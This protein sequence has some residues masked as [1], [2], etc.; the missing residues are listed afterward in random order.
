MKVLAALLRENMKE[1]F[2]PSAVVS[3]LRLPPQ[4]HSVQP[5]QRRAERI[6]LDPSVMDLASDVAGARR[7]LVGEVSTA[8]CM[9]FFARVAKEPFPVPYNC[10]WIEDDLGSRGQPAAVFINTEKREFHLFYTTQRKG[11]K[12]YTYRAAT[13]SIAYES[14]YAALA[15]QTFA[16]E[17]HHIEQMWAVAGDYISA[18][19]FMAA[20]NLVTI[21]KV[22]AD[23]RRGAARLL[24]SKFS[25][26]VFSH[27]RVTLKVP[28]HAQVIEGEV[29]LTERPSGVRLH[30]V[31]G[32]FAR[33]GKNKAWTWIAAHPRGNAALGQVTKT[34][35]VRVAA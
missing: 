2:A 28:R 15:A 22:G 6:L 13:F 5:V 18:L 1:E 8:D 31:S 9:S 3:L 35:T 26:P 34:K 17:N 11:Q 10:V 24:K 27:N 14:G 32:Y 20:E 23:K 7:G 30:E 33:R 12:L 16:A 29:V 25:A 21:R 4:N 19:Q